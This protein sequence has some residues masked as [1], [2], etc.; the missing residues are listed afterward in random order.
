ML[1]L[2]IRRN[3]DPSTFIITQ[4]LEQ[5]HDGK[6]FHSAYVVERSVQITK[7]QETRNA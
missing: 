5:S 4:L 6:L 2:S 1:I 7:R 3:L